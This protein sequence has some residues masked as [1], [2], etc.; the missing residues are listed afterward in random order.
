MVP[1]ALNKANINTNTPRIMIPGTKDAKVSDKDAGTESGIL[2]L[3]TFFFLNK[4]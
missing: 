3:P 2:I 4:W 1:S